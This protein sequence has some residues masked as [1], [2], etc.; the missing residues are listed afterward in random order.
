MFS[1]IFITALI[2]FLAYLVLRSR[3][4]RVA[5]TKAEAVEA[6]PP[7]VS[8]RLVAYIFLGVVAASGGLIYWLEWL[9]DRQVITIRVINSRTGEAV[10]YQAH[11]GKIRGRRF[12]TVDGREVTIADVD[13][14]EMLEP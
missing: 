10:T 9:D 5:A 14:V 4:R 2:I 7:V 3:G 1:K 12:E 13:R 8:P 11:K 6:P